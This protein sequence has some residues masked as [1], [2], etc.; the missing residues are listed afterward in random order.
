MLVVPL[1]GASTGTRTRMLV[2]H[3]AADFKSEGNMSRI[4]YLPIHLF[5]KSRKSIARKANAGAALI[6]FAEHFS[7]RL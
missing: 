6:L 1:V 4:N 7:A 2:M 3:E 5:R